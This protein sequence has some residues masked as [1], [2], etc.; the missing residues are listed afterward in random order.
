MPPPP[1]PTQARHAVARK[2]SATRLRGASY[3]T[4]ARAADRARWRA[5]SSSA[6]MAR[7]LAS[8]SEALRRRKAG[9]LSRSQNDS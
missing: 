6:G 2:L 8:H 7:S 5:R 3:T 1:P 9:T 4:S